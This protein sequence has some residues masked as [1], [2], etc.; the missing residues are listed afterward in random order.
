[1]KKIATIILLAL[2]SNMEINAKTIEPNADSLNINIDKRTKTVVSSGNDKVQGYS[3]LGDLRELF[4]AKN[5]VLSDST[6][7]SI[8]EI[9][10][11]ESNKDTLI[12]I[13]QDGKQVVI[14]F[15]MKSDGGTT[16]NQTQQENNNWPDNKDKWN[17]NPRES[18]KIGWDGIHVKDGSDEVHI[19]RRGLKVIDGGHQEVNIGFGNS[20]FGHEADSI[21][22]VKWANKH[23][24]GSLSGFNVFIGLNSYT[25]ETNNGYNSDDYALKPFGSRYFSMGWTKSA[26]ITNGANARL[27]LGIGV[28]LSWYNFMLE[29]SNSIWTKGPQQI[30]LVPS[31]TSLKKSKLTISY[32]DVPIIPYLS[33]KK[34]KFIE[35]LGFG[36]Y[37]GYRMG[38]HSK[39]KASSRGKKEKEYNNFYLNDFRYGLTLQMG[40]N[41]F[42]D[43]FVNYDLNQLFKEDKGPKVNGISFGIR[44]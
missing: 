13:M 11:S 26:N 6:W 19:S 23:N 15:N 37:V 40:I 18:V 41:N 42:A 28:N 10:N 44:L 1:M 27:K 30:E 14:A 5:M 35:H 3:L 2:F 12:K 39:T 24:Y 8:R 34:G 25:T 9:V 31:A 21:S 33:F 29:N 17:E 4:K 38:S 36:G 32:I 43:L 7:R 16:I 20:E 22:N